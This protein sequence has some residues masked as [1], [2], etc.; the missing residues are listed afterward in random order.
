M[1]QQKAKWDSNGT[2]FFKTCPIDK[3]SDT[4]GLQFLWDSGTGKTQHHGN[5]EN[6]CEHPFYIS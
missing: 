6:F 3:A 4:N 2:A 1:G 5:L